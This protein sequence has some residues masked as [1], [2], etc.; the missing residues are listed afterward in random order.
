M[1]GDFGQHKYNTAPRILKKILLRIKKR[2]QR[3][4]IL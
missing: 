1:L 4:I 2:K 3:K